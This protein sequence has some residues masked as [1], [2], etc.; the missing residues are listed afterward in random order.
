MP[1]VLLTQAIH[2]QAEARLAAL[3]DLCVA[4]D[5]STDTLRRSAREADVIVVRAP[6]PDDIFDAAPRL[7]G[8]VRHG[9]GVDMIPIAAASANGVLVAN[10]PGVNANAVAEHVL[11]CLLQLTRQSASMDQ[12]LRAERSAGWQRA[13]ALADAGTEL[14]GRTLGL[15]GYG[16]VGRTSARASPEARSRS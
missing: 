11:R 13:R 5:T 9:A 14:A 8:A 1:R 16:H 7:I 2:A 6:L 12:K 15:I 3:G 4:P 10:V